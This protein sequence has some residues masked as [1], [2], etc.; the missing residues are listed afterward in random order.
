M[1]RSVPLIMKSSARFTR[2]LVLPSG[3]RLAEKLEA[4]G[5]P[6]RA[7]LEHG[8]VIDGQP[9]DLA[10][11]WSKRRKQIVEAAREDG[12]ANT[13][14]R[15]KKV[16]QIVKQTRGKKTDLPGMD[17]LEARWRKEALAAGW[18]PQAE[19]SRLDRPA[20]TRTRGPGCRKA[21]LRLSVKRSPTSRKNNRSFIGGRSRRWRSRWRSGAASALAVRKAIELMLAE[22]EIVDL[23]QRRHA[24]NQN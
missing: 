14:G 5:V 19:W 7:D 12:L 16:D 13:A 2:S 10:D 24:D 3:F 21:P 22:P 18:T 8:F 17:V 6:V 4:Y 1:D 20:I 15:L 23:Q 11:V 9:S